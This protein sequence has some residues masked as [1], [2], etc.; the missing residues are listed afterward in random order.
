MHL[1]AGQTLNFA[2]HFTRPPKG[3]GVRLIAF[4]A[5]GR[6][7]LVRH[8]YIPGWYLPGGGVDRGETPRAA[9]I[10]EAREEGG[11]AAEGAPQ[12]F[13]TYLRRVTGI[14]DH[15]VVFLVRGAVQDPQ[16]RPSAEIVEARFFGLDDLPGDITPATRARIDEALERAPKVDHW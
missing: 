14:D 9:A 8:S 16:W 15:V 1:F 5:S 6:V 13:N 7:F 3:L 12:L 10:R 11:L 4:D 2:T